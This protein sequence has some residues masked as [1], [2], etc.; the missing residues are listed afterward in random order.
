MKWLEIIISIAGSTIVGVFF[1]FFT[2]PIKRGGINIVNWIASKS[3]WYSD[4]LYQDISIKNTGALNDIAVVLIVGI[5]AGMI[6]IGRNYGE[7]QI[8]N[9][10][11]ALFRMENPELSME[12]LDYKF[13]QFKNAEFEEK[14]FFF[15]SYIPFR[16]FNVISYSFLIFLVIYMPISMFRRTVIVSENRRFKRQLILAGP[17]MKEG[18]AAELKRSWCKMNSKKDFKQI[19]IFLYP[20][21]KKAMDEK[22]LHDLN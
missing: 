6:F 14:S 4:R 2:D 13:Q 5:F 8:N 9:Y 22:L 19:Q 20:Y 12:E 1:V 21:I 16:V 18:V 3:K 17:Y 15:T 11:R 7:N 10:Y